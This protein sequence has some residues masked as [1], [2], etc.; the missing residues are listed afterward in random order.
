MTTSEDKWQVR[1][2]ICSGR[3]VDGVDRCRPHRSRYIAVSAS[4]DAARLD[5]RLR[6]TRGRGVSPGPFSLGG[7]GLARVFNGAAWQVGPATNPPAVP[8][9]WKLPVAMRPAM[10]LRVL[11]VVRKAVRI[12][13]SE[14][15]RGISK[16]LVRALKNKF[17]PAETYYLAPYRT[18]GW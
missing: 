18:I 8:R 3:Y 12:I 6:P 15:S 1:A 4:G 10:L 11:G 5:A 9:C 2:A 7:R 16:C 13:L 14:A 17:L